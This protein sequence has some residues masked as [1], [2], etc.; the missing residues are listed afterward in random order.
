MDTIE[1]LSILVERYQSAG[2]LLPI[3]F[4]GR[5]SCLPFSRFNNTELT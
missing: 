4:I 1:G 3:N 5:C 2:N